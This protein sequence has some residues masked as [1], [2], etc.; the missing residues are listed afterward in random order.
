MRIILGVAAVALTFGISAFAAENTWNGTIS[1]SMCGAKHADGDRACT[2]ACVKKGASLVFVTDDKVYKL[3]DSK[4]VVAAHAGHKVA[5]TGEMNGDTITVTKIAM[6]P[7][8][9]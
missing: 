2:E 8:K 6:Q 4:N 1:D 3:V 7:A 9:K 5:L